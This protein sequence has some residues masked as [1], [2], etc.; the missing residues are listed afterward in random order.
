MAKSFSKMYILSFFGQF[1]FCKHFYFT[2]GV[3]KKINF[4]K[5]AKLFLPILKVEHKSFHMMYLLSYLDIK[6]AWDLDGGVKLTIPSVSWFSS[7]PAG[8]GLKFICL[9]NFILLSSF[10]RSKRVN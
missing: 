9:Y 3:C 10:W 7:T 6:H 2:T 1:F 5:F 4:C 8:I